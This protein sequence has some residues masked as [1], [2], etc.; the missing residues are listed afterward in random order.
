[1]AKLFYVDLVRGKRV[2]FLA[3]PFKSEPIARKYERAAVAVANELDP[4]S[5]FDP[6][7]VVGVDPELYQAPGKVNHLIEIDPADLVALEEAA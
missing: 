3:G 6:F 1:M 7:G 5:H 4:R 2:A